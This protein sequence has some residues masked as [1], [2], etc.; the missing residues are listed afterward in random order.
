MKRDVAVVGA[1]QN[2]LVCAAY[3]ARAGLDVVVLE[4]RPDVGGCAA[5]VDA[6]G[7]RVNVC[8]C[9]HIPVRSTPIADELDLRAHGLRYLDVDPAQ[10]SLSWS[11]A[12]PWLLYHDLERT[13]ESLRAAHPGE[14]EGYRR[15]AAVARPVAQLGLELALGLPTRRRVARILSRRPA[16]AP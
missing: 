11:G 16:A 10:L 5:T 2:G 3:L 1:G 4:A 15:Y 9:G 6:L 7:A 8:N 14:V 12:R 13:L